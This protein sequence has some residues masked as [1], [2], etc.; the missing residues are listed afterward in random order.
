LEAAGLQAASAQCLALGKSLEVAADERD[1][2]EIYDPSL[3]L[4]L[5][6]NIEVLGKYGRAMIGS[7]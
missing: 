3:A 4:Y 1:L 2:R 6:G 5:K 7:S